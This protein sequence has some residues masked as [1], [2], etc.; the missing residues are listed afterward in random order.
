MRA[1]RSCCR[2]FD[3]SRI[4]LFRKRTADAATDERWRFTLTKSEADWQCQSAFVFQLR[5]AL[6]R[7]PKCNSGDRRVIVVGHEAEP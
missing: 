4:E 5:K 3:A 2:W 7:L 6:S 1:V